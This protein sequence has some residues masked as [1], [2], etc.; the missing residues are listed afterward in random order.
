M[1]P[2]LPLGPF[3][4]RKRLLDGPAR[5]GGRAARAGAARRAR[6]ARQQ[7]SAQLLAAQADAERQKIVSRQA[8]TRVA[9]QADLARTKLDAAKRALV[10]AETLHKEGLLNRGDFEKAQD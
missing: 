9:Q 3:H 8:D 4:D 6:S 10:R 2:P 1:A 5:G 7:A